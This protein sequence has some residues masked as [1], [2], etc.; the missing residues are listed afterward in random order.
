MTEAP[1]LPPDYTLRSYDTI[2][3]VVEEARR[4]AASGAEEGTV[5]WAREQRAGRGRFDRRWVSPPG[6]LYS[7]LIL[8][9]EDPAEQAAQMCYV[10]IISLA[11]AMAELIG[12]AELRYR[13]PNDILLGEAKAAGVWLEAPARNPAGGLEWLVIGAA[14]NINAAPPDIDAAQM[15]PYSDRYGGVQPG[16]VLEGYCR[17]FLSWINRWAEEGLAPLHRLWT[18]R[19]N[20]LGAPVELVLRQETLTGTLMEVD[21]EGAALLR[22]ADGSPRRLTVAEFFSI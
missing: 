16:E 10:A 5:V 14:A 7:A 18:Q 4:L 8:R 19:A 13:W 15:A 2:D 12:P 17:Y 1:S 9:P 22:L 6:N 20:G 21:G 3:S 11:A